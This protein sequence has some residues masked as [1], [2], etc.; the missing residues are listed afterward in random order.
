MT[1]YN[2]RF[3]RYGCLIKT[4]ADQKSGPMI[5]NYRVNAGYIPIENWVHGLEGGGRNLGEACHFYDFFTYLINQRVKSFS[6][7]CIKSQNNFLKGNENFNATFNFA[8]GSV[9]NL[10]YT[11]LGNNNVSKEYC[12][13]FFDGKIAILDDYRKIQKWAFVQVFV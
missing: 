3:S 9:A 6:A 1:G 2:R 11:S 4:L 5:P 13:L 7:H 12:E 10:I 8:D